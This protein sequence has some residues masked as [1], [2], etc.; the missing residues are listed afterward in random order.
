MI[1]DLYTGRKERDYE[2][3][4][5]ICFP[6]KEMKHICIS[7]VK[8]CKGEYNNIDYKYKLKMLFNNEFVTINKYV[9]CSCF[10]RYFCY[11]ECYE[12]KDKID[13]VMAKYNV[14]TKT[15]EIN[16]KIQDEEI[17]EWLS[18]MFKIFE[19]LYK[20]FDNLYNGYFKD[21]DNNYKRR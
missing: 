6:N 20:E 19:P 17:L 7:W 2:E 15:Y 12:N 3:Y 9:V 10:G 1:G 18:R 13:C 8:L 5:E 14:K 11:S 16:S 21:L 4:Y